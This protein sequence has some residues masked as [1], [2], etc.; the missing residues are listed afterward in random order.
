M[1]DDLDKRQAET[2]GESGSM[3]DARSEG[4]GGDRRLDRRS[5]FK[6]T[7]ALAVAAGLVSAC[8]TP[9]PREQPP[10]PPRP[11]PESAPQSRVPGPFE[12]VPR[13]PA[14]APDPAI[15]EFFS[16]QE[17]RTVEALAATILPGSPDDPGAREA[18]V[19]NYID[20]LLSHRHGFAE[21]IYRLPP[22]AEPYS[23]EEPP[24]TPADGPQPVW[25]QA[26]ELPRYGYQSS[27]TPREIYRRGLQMVDSYSRSQYGARLTDLSEDDQES[28]VETMADSPGELFDGGGVRGQGGQLGGDEETGFHAPAL[29]EFFEVLRS[30]V[31]EGMFADPLYG[32]NR[33]LVG[34]YMLGYPGAQR[35]YTPP[36]LR[37]EG[38]TREPQSIAQLPHFHPGQPANDHVILPVSGSDRR[39]GR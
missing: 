22:F 5:F 28:V 1:P 31:I 27:L 10:V 35:A 29:R 3:G 13:T 8:D 39:E 11:L 21:A 7:G 12:E 30:H 38:T 9:T 33:D 4:N 34:W 18:G 14:Q 15:L 25:V 24:S 26:D 2:P 37:T 23:G 36:E 6:A 20:H 32:G 19:L 17:A 16:L